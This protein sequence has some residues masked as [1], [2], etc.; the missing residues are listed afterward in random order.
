M[1]RL[2]GFA[3]A[4]RKRLNGDEAAA[5]ANAASRRLA[6]QSWPQIADWVYEQ[7][8]RS[9][10]GG[11]MRPAVLAEILANPAV[12]GLAR[13]ENGALVDV[14]E[15]RAI[16]PETFVELE[17]HNQAKR[18]TDRAE[19]RD[20]LLTGEDAVEF[21]CGLCGTAISAA[22]SNNGSRGYRCAPSTRQ[23]PGGCG[24]VR[25]SADLGEPYIVEHVL[26]E[27]MK[28]EVRSL[29]ERVRDTLLAERPSI[30]QRLAENRSA[31]RSL[32]TRY[33]KSPVLRE[34]ADDAV[35]ATVEEARR[36]LV[37]RLHAA[38]RDLDQRIEVDAARLRFLNQLVFLPRAEVPD[39]I[40]WWQH[41]PM[42]SKRAIIGAMLSRIAIYPAGRGSRTVDG[43]RVA[44]DWRVWDEP[45][46]PQA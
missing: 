10:M 9:T 6:D 15:P 36:E 35:P 5:L 28:P 12:A 11:R 3:D 4:A 43:D 19:G 26:A 39:L 34:A 20:Y 1:P 46:A 31:R 16:S 7:G 13:D 33:G 42:R 22:P 18:P 37:T 40:R 8:H 29:I 23:H 25:L 27:L 21:V 2:F 41:A 44:L 30:E 45:A 17:K 38:Q 32:E 14:G 24:K